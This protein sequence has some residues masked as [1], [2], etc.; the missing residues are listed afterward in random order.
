MPDAVAHVISLF[1]Q[2][3]SHLK[4]EAHSPGQSLL[5]PPGSGPLQP[6]LASE[7]VV[8]WVV[9]KNVLFF[10]FVIFR[11]LKSAPTLFAHDGR[12]LACRVLAL[13]FRDCFQSVIC[14]KMFMDACE[15]AGNEVDWFG[16]GIQ[17]LFLGGVS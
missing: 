1:V 17:L 11:T 5:S 14:S 6:R 3:D 10:C 4:S 16:S 2:M 9:L 7:S 13:P 15:H 12:M 8:G